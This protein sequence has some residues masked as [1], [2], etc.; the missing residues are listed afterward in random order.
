MTQCS[1]SAA[2]SIRNLVPSDADCASTHRAETPARPYYGAGRGAW[3]SLAALLQ[4]LTRKIDMA[5]TTPRSADLRK[6]IHRTRTRFMDSIASGKV[7]AA[8]AEEYTNAVK[9]YRITIFS[10]IRNYAGAKC[11][12]RKHDSGRRCPLE[13]AGCEDCIARG[14]FRRRCRFTVRLA[15]M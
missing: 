7:D 2:D 6:E 3:N 1:G 9:Q 5:A 10:E 8:A 11:E 12:V 4:N 15:P 14:G 13:C